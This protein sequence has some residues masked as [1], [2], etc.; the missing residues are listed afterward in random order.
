MS[1]EDNGSTLDEEYNEEG[2]PDAFV[3]ALGEAQSIEQSMGPEQDRLERLAAAKEVAARIA[4]RDDAGKLEAARKS[5]E[6][7]EK[8]Q[9]EGWVVRFQRFDLENAED[10]ERLESILTSVLS[11]DAVLRAP[12]RY[13]SDDRI[14]TVSW[15]ERGEAK[16]LHKQ[17]TAERAAAHAARHVDP[18]TG[19]PYLIQ[20]PYAGGLLDGEY[21]GDGT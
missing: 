5:K 19:K 21:P 13:S 2:E 14:V 3:T 18:E 9:F 20:P 11:F 1:D 8:H 7:Q 16:K 12:E 4:A 17:K 15:M 10:V 6:P